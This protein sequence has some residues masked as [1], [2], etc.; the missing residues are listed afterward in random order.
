MDS[1]TGRPPAGDPNWSGDAP[2]PSSSSEPWRLYNIGNN[3]SVEVTKVVD[4]L[5]RE[6]GR[7]AVKELVD[8]Q[9]GDVRGHRRSHARYWLYARDPY[10]GRHS[11]LRLL[12]P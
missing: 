2:D 10:R 1:L 8:M 12:V 3:R 5:E 11:T 6:L 7:K 9:P 4:L